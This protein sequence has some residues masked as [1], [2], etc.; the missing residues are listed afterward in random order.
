M[1]DI[2]YA[3]NSELFYI[4][5]TDNDGAVLPLGGLTEATFSLNESKGGISAL[6]TKTLGHGITVTDPT[7]GIL[8]VKISAGDTDG[9]EGYYVYDVMVIV[10]GEEYTVVDDVLE[11]RPTVTR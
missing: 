3:G 4:P 6:L 11:I 10:D 1:S 5:V 9:L 8:T 2:T 7:G